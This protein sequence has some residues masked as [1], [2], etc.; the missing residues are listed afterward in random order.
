[1]TGPIQQVHVDARR[2]GQLH[3]K[4]LIAR[5]TP[6]AVGVDAPRQRVKA[7]ND[8]TRYWHDPH[9]GRFPTRRGDR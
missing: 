8:E 4:D 5:H 1:M 9:G 3:E 2:V 6:Q 7:V